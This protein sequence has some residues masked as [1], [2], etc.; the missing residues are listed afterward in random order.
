MDVH[1][2]AV[3]LEK[4]V[5]ANVWSRISRLT[6]DPHGT[7]LITCSESAACL[8]GLLCLCHFSST[9]LDWIYPKNNLQP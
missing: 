5:I 8:S 3:Y 1:F 9:Q 4:D 6:A 7:G 2:Y